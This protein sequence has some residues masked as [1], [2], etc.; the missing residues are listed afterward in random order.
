EHLLEEVALATC[1]PLLE[2]SV[3]LTGEPDHDERRADVHVDVIDR[4]AAAAVEPV[5]DAQERGQLAQSLLTARPERA[6]L[7]RRTRPAAAVP[8]GERGEQRDP[9]GRGAAQPPR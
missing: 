4:L 6:Q 3:S 2:L 7:L 1:A 5:G 8:P 9:L